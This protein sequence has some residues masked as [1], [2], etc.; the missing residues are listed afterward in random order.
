MCPLIVIS[1]ISHLFLTLVLIGLSLRLT[2]NGAGTSVSFV[3]SV[4]LLMDRGGRIP[5]IFLDPE[6]PC[7]Y[8][9][10]RLRPRTSVYRLCLKKW[11]YLT[12]FCHLP[13][14]LSFMSL[15]CKRKACIQG[16][17]KICCRS[18]AF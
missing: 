11:E 14:L 17:K 3:N 6:L 7:H 4:E 13:G 1:L 16:F 9:M 10:R 2:I 18:P 5:S 15:N 8:W 12:K